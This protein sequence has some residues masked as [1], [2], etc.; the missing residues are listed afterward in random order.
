MNKA[1]IYLASPFFTEE[2]RKVKARVKKHLEKI[3]SSENMEIADPQRVSDPFNWEKENTQWG[4]E[5]YYKDVQL[6]KSCDA[7]VAIDWGLYGDCGTAFEVGFAMALQKNVIV[8]CPKAVTN[9]P[10]SLMVANGCDNLII[11]DRFF[12]TCCYGDLFNLDYFA[13]GVVQE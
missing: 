7:V 1:K 4:S 11:E 6:L 5:T 13:K 3:I 9:Q 8:I 10:H 12:T 2:Q